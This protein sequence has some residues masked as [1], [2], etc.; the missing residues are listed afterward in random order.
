MRLFLVE[1]RNNPKHWFEATISSNG[2]IQQQQEEESNVRDEKVH[3]RHDSS[4]T[5]SKDSIKNNK[6]SISEKQGQNSRKS[7]S[8]SVDSIIA[9][10]EEGPI[11]TA[12]KEKEDA[13][14][15][16]DNMDDIKSL[17]S[18]HQTTNDSQEKSVSQTCGGDKEKKKKSINILR[19][20]SSS[21]VLAALLVIFCQGFVIGSIQV[22]HLFIFRLCFFLL[23]IIFTLY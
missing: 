13:T 3:N 15:R 5:T 19:I 23:I 21:R 14:E 16:S 10:L 6:K 17:S 22:L 4:S 8:V 12:D 11:C 2:F 9:N 20:L 1:R 7:D 18:Q